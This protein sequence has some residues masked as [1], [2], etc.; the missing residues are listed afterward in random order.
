MMSANKQVPETSDAPAPEPV[1]EP[2]R[3]PPPPTNAA[4]LIAGLLPNPYADWMDE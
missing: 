3:A 4:L 1:K 2:R